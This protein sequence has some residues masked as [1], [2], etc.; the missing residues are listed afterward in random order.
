MTIDLRA[1]TEYEVLRAAK[2]LARIDEAA[3]QAWVHYLVVGATAR[4][5]ISFD[6]S[7]RSPGRQ[8]RDIDIAA[9]V[10]S[11]EEFDSLV[12]TLARCGNSVHKFVV[13]GTEVDVVPYG[14]IERRDRTIVWPDDHAMNVLGFREAVETARTVFLPDGAIV[15]IPSIPALALLKIFAWRDRHRDDTRD[16]LDLATMIEWYSSGK[17]FDALY[18]ENVHALEKFDYDPLPA[19]AWLLG[20]HISALLDDDGVAA[21]LLILDDREL[22]GRLAAD[23][24]SPRSRIVVE[25]VGRG[26]HDAVDDA[27]KLQSD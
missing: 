23:M 24:R 4:S 15:K 19:G 26:V 7:G 20:A 22:T 3:R 2:V 10:D 8:T 1:S 9:M 11:W 13:E 27:R 18:G 12:R 21:L 6:L 5:L 17:Y 16:A 25:A 14:G